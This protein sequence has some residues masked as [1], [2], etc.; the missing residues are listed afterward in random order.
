MI[1][2]VVYRKWHAFVG[3]VNRTGR[4]VDQVFYIIMAAAFQNIQ[5][6]NNIAINIGVW[7][8]D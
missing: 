2:I 4:S 8:F 3:T 6:S 5:E 1:D 7:V